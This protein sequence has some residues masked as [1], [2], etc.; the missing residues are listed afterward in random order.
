MIEETVMELV[1]R[2]QKISIQEIGLD[3]SLDDIGI[4]SLGALTLLFEIED[5][6][7][8]DIPDDFA[9]SLRTVG[10]IVTKLQE[11]KNEQA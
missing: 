11:I 6:L 8:V 7:G 3:T 5:R 10:D 4:D 9:K 2:E 1:A